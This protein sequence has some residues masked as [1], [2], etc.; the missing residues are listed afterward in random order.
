MSQESQINSIIKQNTERSLNEWENQ[1]VIKRKDIQYFREDPIK[2]REPQK[3]IVWSR[4]DVINIDNEYGTRLADSL[5]L[6][7]IRVSADREADI[8]AIDITDDIH[9][10]RATL[11]FSGVH[12]PMTSVLTGRFNLENILCAAGAAF[13]TG[14]CPESIARGIAALE[15]VPGRVEKSQV[16]ERATP[17]P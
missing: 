4:A 15:R 10:L 6:P 2:I 7:V 8:R 5:N 17:R 13:A 3:Y 16:P 9:G 14:V 11:D 12:A 1:S